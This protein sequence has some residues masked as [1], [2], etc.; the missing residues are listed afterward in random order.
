MANNITQHVMMK[1]Y[2]ITQDIWEK[3]IGENDEKV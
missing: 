3:I 1:F 2:E